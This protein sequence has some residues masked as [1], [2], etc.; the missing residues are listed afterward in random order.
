MGTGSGC[1]ELASLSTG[2]GC[3]ELA[4]L[5]TRSGC[6]EQA[7][8]GGEVSSSTGHDGPSSSGSFGGCSKTFPSLGARKRSSESAQH[9]LCNERI[10]VGVGLESDNK[11]WFAMVVDAGG[12]R[13][14]GRDSKNQKIRFETSQ[15]AKIHF[16]SNSTMTNQQNLRS[17]R[18]SSTVPRLPLARTPTATSPTCFP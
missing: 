14:H 12:E 8:M 4:S 11:G 6:F 1:F 17:K 15:V 7:S 3:F 18:H 13:W 10:S 2:S 16:Q 5:G 9:P